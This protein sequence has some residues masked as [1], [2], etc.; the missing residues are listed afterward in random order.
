[1]SK[2]QCDVEE[3]DRLHYGRGYCK[4][5]YSR[6]R[7]WGDP[8]V[9]NR[10]RCASPEE[11]FEA[12]TMPVTETGCLLWT[13]GTFAEGY[14]GI[15]VDGRT[16]RAHRYAWE[17]EHGPIP[18]G[19]HIDHRCHTRAC[20]N[21]AHLR[22]ATHTENTRNKS[23]PA[24]NNTSGHRGV[25]WNK[26]TGKWRARIMLDGRGIHLGYFAD[27][28]EAADVVRAAREEL[29]GEFAGKG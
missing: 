9:V 28:E 16:I 29:Y 22:L 19:M 1:M 10:V 25:S 6:W 7:K 18:K 15:A 4:L 3:C 27:A 26:G 24:S 20:C 14:G 13:G 21:V 5:H 17:R 11:S 23:G 12:R 8:M 2:R